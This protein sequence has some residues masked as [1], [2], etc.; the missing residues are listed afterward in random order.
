MEAED[1][2][3]EK[4][5]LLLTNKRFE[6]VTVREYIDT[7]ENPIPFGVFR[8]DGLEGFEIGVVEAPARR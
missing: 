2:L 7:S 6:L 4:L 5:E 1:L 8:R 3:D